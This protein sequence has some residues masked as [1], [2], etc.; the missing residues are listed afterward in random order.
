MNRRRLILAVG[1]VGVGGASGVVAAACGPAGGAGTEAPKATAERVTIEHYNFFD[2]E[3]LERMKPVWEKF[4]QAQ[5]NVRVEHLPAEGNEANKREKMQA[6]VAGGTPPAVLGQIIAQY[7]SYYALP[8]LIEPLD[9]LV[10]GDKIDK[11][12]FSATPYETFAYKGVQYALPYGA[13][14]ELIAYNKELFAKQGIK[15]PPKTWDDPSWTLGEFLTRAQA[16]TKAPAGGTPEQFGLQ[17]S[18]P[19]WNAWPLVWG[20]DWVDTTLARFQ[21]T[22]QA[23][24]DAL[25]ARQDFVW[26]QHVAP[27]PTETGMFGS[28][29]SSQ[30]FLGGQVAM[31][32]MGT[33]NLPA[34]IKGAKFGWDVA[35]WYRGGTGAAAGSIYPVGEAIGKGTKHKQQAWQLV[36]FLTYKAD[37]NLDYAFLKGAAPALTANLTPWRAMLTKEMPGITAQIPADLI[38]RFGKVGRLHFVAKYD[39][40]SRLIAPV[41]TDVEANKVAAKAALEQVTPQVQQLLG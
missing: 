41:V 36:K 19:Q 5:P 7:P 40:I 22:Q 25:Q 6:L 30:R 37:A 8:G 26:R 20:T 27:Q 1:V 34:W 33:W 3:A 24:I 12:L 18:G 32:D 11:K 28:L 21:G 2:P 4:H 15:E 35:P 31:A 13:S 9:A 16:L 38:G 14:M 10:T 39:D 29:S 23:V 17:R